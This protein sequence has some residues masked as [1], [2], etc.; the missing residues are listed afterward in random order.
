[1]TSK[2]VVH[3]R[4]GSGT[5]IGYPGLKKAPFMATHNICYATLNKHPITLRTFCITV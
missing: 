2:N 4:W 1:M 5:S 3:R